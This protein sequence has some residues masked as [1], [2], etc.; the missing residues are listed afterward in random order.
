MAEQIIPRAAMPLCY[1]DPAFIRCL[2]EGINTTELVENFDRLYGA[3]ILSRKSAI[4]KMVDEATGKQESDFRAFAEFVHSAIY[5]RL[6]D[7]AIQS[8]RV[9]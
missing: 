5:M 8:L 4:E 7:E 2:M 6:P 3:S 1:A 9:A